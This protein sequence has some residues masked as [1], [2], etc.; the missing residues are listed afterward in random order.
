V[1]GTD[2]RLDRVLAFPLQALGQVPYGCPGPDGYPDYAAAWTSTSQSLHRWNLA[3]TLTS[4]LL[5][6]ISTQLPGPAYSA[7][8]LPNVIDELGQ[9]LL[10]TVL[11]EQARAILI[12]F[13]GALQ[14]TG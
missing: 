13:A 11:P 10:G 1:T 6:G 3:L 14:G 8:E 5:P 2:G 4:G 9:A 7:S 12:E